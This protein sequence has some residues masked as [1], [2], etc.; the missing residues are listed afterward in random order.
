VAPPLSTHIPPCPSSRRRAANAVG[1]L[2]GQHPAPLC[3]PGRCCGP[4][5]SRH[6]GQA[7]TGA[8]RAQQHQPAPGQPDP[9]RPSAPA[10]AVPAFQVIRDP[11][12][13]P[14]V[15]SQAPRDPVEQR[16]TKHRHYTAPQ[17]AG[18]PG[19]NSHRPPAE[20]RSPGTT[21][22][23]KPPRSHG[24]PRLLAG[25]RQGRGSAGPPAPPPPTRGILPRALAPAVQ[26]A[27]LTP[28]ILSLSKQ[29]CIKSRI[30]EWK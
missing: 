5:P 26:L 11:S 12:L 9:H 17:R 14:D 10:E 16:G 7:G 28:E 13:Q 21:S 29:P 6:Q 20:D 30:Q 24:F 3:S 15:P 27:P 4:G 23:A 25:R 2:A 22:L 1:S 19:P 8:S 18:T